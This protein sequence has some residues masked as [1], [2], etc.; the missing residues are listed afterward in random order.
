MSELSHG[1]L[2]QDQ[3]RLEEAEAC[4]YSVLAREP[5]NDFVYGR[6]ALCQMSQPGKK[7]RALDTIAEAIRLRADEPFYFSVKAIVLGELHRGKE[8]LEAAETAVRLNPEDTFALSAKANAYCAM[9]RWAEAEE[10]SRHAL[11]LDGD[12]AMAANILAHTLRMQ[13]KRQLN[14][15]AVERLLAAD[16]EDSFAHVN[17]GWTALQAKDQPRAEQHFREAL[18][19]DPESDMAR[20]GLLESFR[21]RSWF[22]RAYLSYCF[23]MQRYTEG[24]QWMIFLGAFAVYQVSRKYLE[25]L[26]PVY[27]GVLV[28]VWLGLVL[29]VWLAPGIGNFLILLD[30]SARLALK[31]AERHQGIA[32]GGVF[33]A[34]ALAT[35][36]GLVSGYYPIL[37][38][39]VGMLATTIPASLTFGNASS[40][41]RLVFGSITVL[42][43]MAAGIMI[44]LEWMHHPAPMHPLSRALGTFALVAT[45]ACTWLGNIRSLRRS[46]D[47]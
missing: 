43:Y 36:A 22:Y 24:K 12:N 10:W 45:V 1:L 6:L 2:L 40:R 20:E 4:F 44:V 27:S 16:P 42:L 47:D 3:G 7:R 34:G 26:N 33:I 9:D 32:V 14:A 13:G 17:A 21:A 5:D 11:A 38:A 25:S 28:A 29:W 39:G 37:L 18:R 8:A 35:I 15:E 23:F 30:R 31:P 46:S 19:L 41:G